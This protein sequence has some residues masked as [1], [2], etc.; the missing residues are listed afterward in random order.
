MSVAFNLCID[1]TFEK[2][3]LLFQTVGIEVYAKLTFKVCKNSLKFSLLFQS[4][5]KI[6]QSCLT[7]VN[8]GLS[9]IRLPGPWDS[10]GKNTRV[11]SHFHLQGTSQ[12]RDKTWVSYTAELL[13]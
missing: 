5:V 11:G 8:L 9:P 3:F 6:S 13:F 12:P 4:E 7:S 1:I 2:Y 10:P